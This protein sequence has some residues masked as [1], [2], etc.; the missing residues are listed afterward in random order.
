MELKLFLS[1]GSFSQSI[2]VATAYDTLGEEGLQHSI[3]ETEAKGCFVNGDQLATL[4]NILPRCPAV[5]III[6]RGE[7]DA[8]QLDRLKTVES[9]K[10]VI[11]FDDLLGLGQAH[12]TPAVKPSPADLS[13]IMYTSGSTG[14]PK[15]V[16][17][18]HG[19]VIAAGRNRSIYSKCTEY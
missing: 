4:E 16:Q 14:N 13:L 10:Y 12:P 17:L 5:Q 15:G 19:N 7:A 11:A 8:D 1:L 3:N 9:I 2:T 6:Y 18:T